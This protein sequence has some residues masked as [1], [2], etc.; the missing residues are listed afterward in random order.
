MIRFLQQENRVQKT[1]FA[2]IIGAAIVTMVITLVPGIFDNGAANDAT[3]FA[4]VR[5]PGFF[6]RITGDSTPIKMAD[7]QRQVQGQLKR[8]NLPD[9]YM[10]FLLSR[11]GQQMVERKVLEREADRLGLQASKADVQ[12]ELLQGPLAQYVAPGGNYIGDDQYANFVNSAFGMSVPDFENEVRADIELQR[13]QALITGGVSVPDSAVRSEYLQQGTKVKFAYATITAADLGKTINPSDADLQAFFKNNA[14]RY[15]TAVPETRK[16]QYFSF[17]ASNMPG[18]KPQVTDADVQAYYSKH[19]DEYN[20]A[21]QIKTRHILIAVAKGADAKTD[22]AGKAKAEDVLKQ[23]KSGGNFADLAKKY[24]DDPGSKDQGGEL[25]LQPSSLFVPEFSKAAM[26]LNPGQTSDL[27]RTQFGYHIIQLEE[28]QSA[29][30]KPLAEVKDQIV[31][32][33]QQGKVGAAEQNFA[34]QLVGEAK[35]DGMS[36]AAADNHLPLV[37]TDYIGRSATIPNFPAAAAM[38]TSAFTAD[39]NATPQ[40]ATTG[41]GYAIFQVEDIHPAHAPEFSDYKSHILDD[42]RQQHVPEL[43]NTQLKK[44]DDRAKVL[45]DLSKAAAEMNI[46]VKTSDLVG[47]D[48]QVTDLG[49]LT[50]PA[51]VVFTLPKGGIS[52]AINQGANGSVLQVVDKQEPSADDMAKNFA[53]T[54]DK[55][56]DQQKQEAFGIFI[57][58]LMEKYEKNGAIIYSKKAQKSPLAR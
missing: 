36:K 51:S 32:L 14:A 33:L 30:T 56:L 4:T 6:G 17:D 49:S 44:L 26:A 24:S 21:E 5:T 3:V 11:V 8:Q 39:K 29:H 53:A 12:H 41:T 45:N 9:F 15:A 28:K 42:Y 7:V 2:V 48:A 50:G 22:A 10:P 16:I 1:V 57:G 43:L 31:T 23:I 19:Q 58:T 54:K 20:V 38:L 27:V 46:P 40:M 18:G 13:L 55:L 52:D 37:S 34:N 47:R 35:K 25:G